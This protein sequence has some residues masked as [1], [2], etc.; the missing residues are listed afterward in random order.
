MSAVDHRRVLRVLL[1]AALVALGACG[2]GVSSA[3][4]PTTTTTTQPA[5]DLTLEA[6]ATVPA[7][8]FFEVSFV[9]EVPA[10]E[11]STGDGASLHRDGKPVWDLSRHGAGVRVVEGG[12]RGET[13]EA[14]GGYGPFRYTAPPEP[15]T[16]ELCKTAWWMTAGKVTACT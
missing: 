4:E 16:Y 13:A 2:D 12:E 9:T 5:F 15:G 7:G 11:L 1:V 3:D 8:W 10:R 14:L 6:P